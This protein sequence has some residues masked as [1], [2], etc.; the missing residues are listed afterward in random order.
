M[1]LKE[2]D[3]GSASFAVEDYKRPTFAVT[4]APVTALLPR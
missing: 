4:F 3:H 2:T 1:H